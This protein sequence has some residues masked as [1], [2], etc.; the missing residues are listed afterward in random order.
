MLSEAKKAILQEITKENT[1][2]GIPLNWLKDFVRKSLH[3]DK[4]KINQNLDELKSSI[5]SFVLRHPDEFERLV[6]LHREYEE[7][8]PKQISFFN[9]QPEYHID[10]KKTTLSAHIKNKLP[11]IPY[12]FVLDNSQKAII[13][14]CHVAKNILSLQITE[15]KKLWQLVD[16]KEYTKNN[17][18]WRERK[19]KK[20]PV[21]IIRYYSVDTTTGLIISKIDVIGQGYSFREDNYDEILSADLKIITGVEAEE[22]YRYKTTLIVPSVVQSF[23]SSHDVFVRKSSDEDSRGDK[24]SYTKVRTQFNSALKHAKENKIPITKLKLKYPELDLHLSHLSAIGAQQL[25]EEKKEKIRYTS[26]DTYV[27]Y[28]NE[29][30]YDFYHVSI[31]AENGVLKT[32]GTLRRSLVENEIYRI[33]GIIQAESNSR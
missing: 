22:H 5:R 16:E 1:N 29:N 4:P 13:N 12:E 25:L 21:K 18:E 32:F 14:Y 8:R 6:S 10:G 17:I 2:Y 26:A 19:Q 20:V 31:S 27:V 11:M 24:S 28:E 9:W 33:S 3:E 30:K 7:F 15:H 23:I